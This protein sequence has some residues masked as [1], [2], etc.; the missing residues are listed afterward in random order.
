MLSIYI[1]TDDIYSFVCIIYIQ[2][3]NTG[4][5]PNSGFQQPTWVGSCWQIVPDQEC[6]S[7][8][9]VYGFR[10]QGV[11]SQIDGFSDCSTYLPFSMQD[12]VCNAQ[13]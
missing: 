5:F 11:L 13:L 10:V 8:F 3:T 2:N 1:Y 6:F 7:G 12:T 9:G 4:H